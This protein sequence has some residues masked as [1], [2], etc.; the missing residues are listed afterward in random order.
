MIAGLCN[1]AKNLYA[2]DH[3]SNKY[4]VLGSSMEV[5]VHVLQGKPYWL[6][7]CHN[8]FYS[9]DVCWFKQKIMEKI[10]LVSGLITI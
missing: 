7:N 2:Y 1:I 4:F 6:H 10:A 8:I 9:M 5:F 3:R